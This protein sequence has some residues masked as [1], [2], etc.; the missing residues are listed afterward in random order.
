M[1]EEPS[2]PAASRRSK[3]PRVLV[4]GKSV[5]D[6][7]SPER[8]NSFEDFQDTRPKGSEWT[9][10]TGEASRIVKIWA[11]DPP[12][13]DAQLANEATKRWTE[14]NQGLVEI[15][16][17]RSSQDL[18]HAKQAYHA[19]YKKSLEEDVAYHTTRDFHKVTISKDDAVIL[20]GEGDKKAIEERCEQ[21]RSKIEL[22]TSDYDK[23]KH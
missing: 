14:S 3:R 13:C 4:Y 10:V 9:R 11:L 6:V 12:V 20:D 21:V 8:D 19:L 5:V 18:L 7:Q 2:A 1:E 15:A 23:E 17:T 16:C 22:S